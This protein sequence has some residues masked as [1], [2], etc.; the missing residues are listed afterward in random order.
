MFRIT[1]KKGFH[2]TFPNGY[3]VSVQFGP[4]N[5]CD[6]Y[7]GDFNKAA[8][9]ASQ[10][11]KTAECAVWGPDGKFFTPPPEW[12]DDVRGYMPPADVLALLNWAASLPTES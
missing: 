11:S 9:L 6:H 5:Y 2:L 7:D 1:Q 10:G 12:G 4:G 3:T 8:E